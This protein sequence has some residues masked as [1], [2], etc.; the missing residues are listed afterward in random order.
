MAASRLIACLPMPRFVRH[1][2]RLAPAALVLVAAVTGTVAGAANRPVS[3][4]LVIDG[5]DGLVIEGVHIRTTRGDC[6]RITRSRNIMVR[7]SE[8]GPCGGNGVRIAGGDGITIVDSYIHPQTQSVGCC[9]AHDG[10]FAVGTSRLRIQGNV[11]AYGESNIEIHDSSHVTAK[12]NFLLNPRGPF[13]R[14]QNFQCW[15]HA[16]DGTGPGCSDITV[17]NNYALSSRVAGRWLFPEATQDSINFG[18]TRNAVASNNFISGGHSQAG[19]GLIADAG[20]SNVRMTGNRLVDTGQCGIGIADGIGNVVDG[21]T[22]F[23]RTPIGGGGNQGIYVWQFYGAKGRCAN[24]R[25]VNNLA[26]SLQPGGV[27]SGFWKGPGCD[28]L[29]LAHNR[30]AAEAE[31]AFASAEQSMRPPPIPP[32]PYACAV[33]SPYTNNR[34]RPS[35]GN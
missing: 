10:V 13:P 24:T 14:G 9:D 6:L 16:G 2:M 20:A 29:V 7:N 3:G 34:A 31:A 18:M 5:K 33:K 12:G 11:I 27:R 17:D 4:A 15:S 21:N 19:C 23:N 26:L 35:C 22:V 8:I 30:F 32:E 25:V 28:P 1:L